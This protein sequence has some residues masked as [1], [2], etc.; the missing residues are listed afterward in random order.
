MQI[1]AI[2]FLYLQSKMRS[3]FF[4]EKEVFF[5]ALRPLLSLDRILSGLSDN[6]SK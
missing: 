1:G 5:R 4:C 3:G 6:N 2:V